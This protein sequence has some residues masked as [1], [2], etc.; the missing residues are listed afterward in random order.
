MFH[1]SPTSSSVQTWTPEEGWNRTWTEK[2]KIQCTRLYFFFHH[3][4]HY[5][6][7]AA[8]I[9]AHMMVYKEKCHGLQYSEEQERELMKALQLPSGTTRSVAT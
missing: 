8:S 2:D 6:S 9:M 3:T 5:S 7:D 4:K 1:W